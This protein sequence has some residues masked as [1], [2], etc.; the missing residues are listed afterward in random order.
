MQA[1]EV[2]TYTQT[3]TINNTNNYK[4][5]DTNSSTV[6]IEWEINLPYIGYY[7]YSNT[8]YGYSYYGD[9][10]TL[11]TL[12]LDDFTKDYRTL[13]KMF[14]GYELNA[15]EDGE[16]IYEISG[17]GVC[18]NESGQR[19][20]IGVSDSA[21]DYAETLKD[22]FSYNCD[23]SYNYDGGADINCT[24]NDLNVSISTRTG[25]ANIIMTE[26]NGNRRAECYYDMDY[27][28]YCY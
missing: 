26:P 5:Y 13:G 14:Y 27:G 24:G 16:T 20:C 10:N 23:G 12:T 4:W 22:N 7:Y 8:G 1:I 2:G 3:C 19:F 21:H 11:D 28:V 6:S 9:N 18:G 15:S 17:V 25:H